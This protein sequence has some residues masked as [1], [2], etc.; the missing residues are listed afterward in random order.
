[1]KKVKD[2]NA[3]GIE[4]ILVPLVC[5]GLTWFHTNLLAATCA[6]VVGWLIK[7]AITAWKGTKM[8]F[9]PKS[10]WLDELPLTY[11]RWVNYLA[12]LIPSLII[13]AILNS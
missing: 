12:Y 13:T 1:M 8:G 2:S 7:T 4:F 9:D 11:I 10:N 6:I 3:I 5:F